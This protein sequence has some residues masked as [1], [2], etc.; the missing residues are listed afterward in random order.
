[1]KS[2]NEYI[3]EK[4]VVNKD[5]KDI[6]CKELMEY[7]EDKYELIPKHPY[8]WSY[9]DEEQFYDSYYKNLKDDL[10]EVLDEDEVE[11][12]RQI[13]KNFDR[14][15]IAA[16]TS[17]YA[18]YDSMRLYNDL[19]YFIKNNNLNMTEISD[20]LI[21]TEDNDNIIVLCGKENIAPQSNDSWAILIGFDSSKIK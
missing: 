9:V 1:M 4:L 21:Y 19:R 2:L 13:C 7:L 14:F 6:T 18:L 5:Y 20:E 12:I 10:D 11:K 17:D 15:L 3:S 8:K 16:D